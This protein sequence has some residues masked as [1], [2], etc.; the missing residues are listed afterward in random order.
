MAIFAHLS[1]LHLRERSG[2]PISAKKIDLAYARKVMSDVA[3]KET[4]QSVVF[5]PNRRE[6]YV[7]LATPG[8]PATTIEP[9]RFRLEDLLRR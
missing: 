3:V 6:L 1:N 8:V 4:L 2:Y 5:F 7:S 9:T